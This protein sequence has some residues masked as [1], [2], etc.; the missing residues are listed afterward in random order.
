MRFIGPSTLDTITASVVP[1][2]KA[3]ATTSAP[4]PP[5]AQEAQSAYASQLTVVPELQSYGALLN[6]SAKPIPLTE[7]ETEYVVSCVKHIFKEHVVFQVSDALVGLKR[8]VL[9]A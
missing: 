1:K 2:S 5:S 8:L 3:A 4:V 7:S 9:I 6:S